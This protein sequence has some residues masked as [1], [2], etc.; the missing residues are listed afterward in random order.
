MGSC[1]TALIATRLKDLE[2]AVER[3]TPPASD[4]GSQKGISLMRANL[5]VDTMW[6]PVW[7]SESLLAGGSHITL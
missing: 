7:K 4:D 2:I 6:T 5:T 3:R 1:R